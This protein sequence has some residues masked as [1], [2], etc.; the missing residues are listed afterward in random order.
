MSLRSGVAAVDVAAQRRHHFLV[1]WR[2]KVFG[3][4]RDRRS[5]SGDGASETEV[6]A[7]GRRE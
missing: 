2:R 1:R 7:Y 6:F 5:G 4:G 3:R